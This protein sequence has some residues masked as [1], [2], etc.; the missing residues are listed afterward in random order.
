MPEGKVRE[1]TKGKKQ[2]D[3]V[4][5][6][7]YII[8]ILVGIIG[9]LLVLFFPFLMAYGSYQDKKN[10]SYAG[11]VTISVV[12]LYSILFVISLVFLGFLSA[13]I[14]GNR[15]RTMNGAVRAGIVTAVPT[16]LILLRIERSLNFISPSYTDLWII[17]PLLP[18]FT[19]LSL[20]VLFQ[21]FGAVCGYFWIR[22][23]PE[24][25]NPLH[26]VR[27]ELIILKPTIVTMAV[28]LAII[29]IPAAYSQMVPAK[30]KFDG[31]TC[32][33][34]YDAVG[35][36]RVS[37]DTIRITQLMEAPR[38]ECPFQFTTIN[39]IF[40]N[41]YEVSNQSII[42]MN[43]LSDTIDPP[44]G[45]VYAKGSQVILKGPDVSNKSYDPLIRV[46]KSRFS[47]N[48]SVVGYQKMAEYNI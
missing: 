41:D 12:D 14:L 2:P 46:E 1:M 24:Y 25:S 3:D 16:L 23:H 30:L 39:K 15:I 36:E 11:F 10:V 26:P 44:E 48:G 38:E 45:L 19:I 27:W 31:Y 5:G 8:P 35:V 42:H 18:I 9:G 32:Y 34:F 28:I 33:G 13:C 4:I 29:V 37:E 21:A 40:L 7:E 47:A 20:A 43:G 22:M 6:I 17:S